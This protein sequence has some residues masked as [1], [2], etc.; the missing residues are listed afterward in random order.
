M[1][2]LSVQILNQY[3]K[4]NLEVSFLLCYHSNFIG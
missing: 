1:K 2:N 3:V 4:I